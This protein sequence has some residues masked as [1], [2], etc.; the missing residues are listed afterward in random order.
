MLAGLRPQLR[1]NPDAGPP[2][3]NVPPHVSD[4]PMVWQS[5]ALFP[6]LNARENVV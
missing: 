6:F 5:L 4:T 3:N 1:E 2:M